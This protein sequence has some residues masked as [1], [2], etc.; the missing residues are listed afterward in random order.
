MPVVRKTPYGDELGEGSKDYGQK[1]SES[2][3]KSRRYG[4]KSSDSGGKSLT[5]FGEDSEDI[6]KP[7]SWSSMVVALGDRYDALEKACQTLKSEN[8][9]LKSEN[10]FLE[11]EY[12]GLLLENLRLQATP[13][14]ILSARPPPRTLSPGHPP[15]STRRESGSAPSGFAGSSATP[16]G[17]RLYRLL[18]V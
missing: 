1:S 18:R 2:G 17:S 6:S 12:H 8:D 15:R 7:W 14:R 11:T 3:G 9:R 16:Q 4:Q 13:G 10:D 5:D